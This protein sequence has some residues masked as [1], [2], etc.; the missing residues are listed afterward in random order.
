MCVNQISSSLSS[1]HNGLVGD[2]RFLLRKWTVRIVVLWVFTNKTYNTTR[3]FTSEKKN[4]GRRI[5]ISLGNFAWLFWNESH[6]F[7]RL[8]KAV[9]Y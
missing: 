1:V 7:R 6:A 3:W 4:E 2:K 9:I 8:K 5:R